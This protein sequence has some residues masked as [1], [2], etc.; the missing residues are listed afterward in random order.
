MEGGGAAVGVDCRLDDDAALQDSPLLSTNSPAALRSTS[1]Q[2]RVTEPDLDFFERTDVR[3]REAAA[4]ARKMEARE[5]EAAEER[6]REEEERRRQE[7]LEAR[8]REIG[9]AHV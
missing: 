5:R 2:L 9:R 1:V 3:E 6:E 8:E 7:E 4:A